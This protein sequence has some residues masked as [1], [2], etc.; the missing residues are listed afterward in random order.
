MNVVPIDQPDTLPV[1]FNRGLI[2]AYH[3]WCE[4]FNTNHFPGLSIRSISA[5]TSMMS[6]LNKDTNIT[7]G[8]R[9]NKSTNSKSPEGVKTHLV[10]RLATRLLMWRR[11]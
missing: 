5:A 1:I 9:Q 6:H 2:G 4:S 10:V 3:D 7:M 11:S 8:F